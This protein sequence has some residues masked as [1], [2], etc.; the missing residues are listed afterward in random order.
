MGDPVVQ[1]HDKTGSLGSVGVAFVAVVARFLA[2]FIEL[3][4][5]HGRI[6]LQYFRLTDSVEQN[7]MGG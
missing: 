1:R 3:R 4:H 6:S 2:Q 5:S 7:K